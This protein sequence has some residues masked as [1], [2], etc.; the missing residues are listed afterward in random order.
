MGISGLLQ[1]T[2]NLVSGFSS[3]GL[4]NSGVK[5]ISQN[6][7]D[8]IKTSKSIAVLKRLV[9]ITGIIGALLFLV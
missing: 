9:W 5:H 6:Q 7:E 3:L 1:T 8:S 2:L 4:E